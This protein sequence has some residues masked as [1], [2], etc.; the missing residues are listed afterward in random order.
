MSQRK[1][2]LRQLRK[3][4]EAALKTVGAKHAM[5]FNIGIMRFD[6]TTVRCKLQGAN[7]GSTSAS[8]TP[9]SLEMIT[10]LNHVKCPAPGWSAP[11]GL[12]ITKQYIIPALG[13]VKVVGYKP[14]RRKYPY[15]VQKMAGIGRRFK[16]SLSSLEAAVKTGGA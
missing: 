9:V 13:L 14:S 10:L 16:I 7:V 12:D 3:D 15:I 11:L 2:Q 6:A 8:A 4:L 1:F 5:T